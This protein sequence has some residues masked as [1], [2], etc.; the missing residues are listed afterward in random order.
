MKFLLACVVLVAA[1][2]AHKI[3]EEDD[4]ADVDIRKIDERREFAGFVRVNI[5]QYPNLACALATCLDV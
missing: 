1:V 2:S 4:V 5:T 3:D